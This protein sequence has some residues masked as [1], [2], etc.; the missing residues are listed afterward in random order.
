MRGD[1]LPRV[2]DRRAPRQPAR[3][4]RARRASSGC[5]RAGCRALRAVALRGAAAPGRGPVPS[6][7]TLRLVEVGRATLLRDAPFAPWIQP[8][9]TEQVARAVRYHAPQPS[10]V[11]LADGVDGLSRTTELATFFRSYAWFVPLQPGDVH[12]W[13][14]GAYASYDRTAARR[15]RR[16]LG[17]VPGDGADRRADG[18]VADVARRRAAAAAARRRDRS[19]A[20]RVHRARGGGAATRGRRGAPTPA[21][22]RCAA[23]A[24]G[25]A[26][27]RRDRERWRSWERSPA[28]ASAG[29]SPRSSP[30]TPGSPALAGR[31]ALAAPTG[32]GLAAALH[33][34]GRRGAPALP[35][36]PRD[37]ARRRPARAHAARRRRARCGRRRRGRLRA[38]IGRR[39]LARAAAAAERSCCSCR[40]SSRSPPRSVR[41]ACSLP[42]LRVL[43]RARPPRSAAR[44][45]ALSLARNPGQATVVATF[46][47]A[48]LG[49]A[50]F[51]VI[52]RATLLQGQH[53]QAYYAVPAPYVA[54]EDLSQL[55]PVLHG[56]HG[57]PRDSRPAA[58][59]QRPGDDRVHLPRRSRRR[60]SRLRPNAS[61]TVALPRGTRASRC[62]RRVQ[63]DDVAVR[64]WFRSPLGDFQA[65]DAS[66]RRTERQRVVLHGRIPFASAPARL[67]RARPDQLAAAS[68]RTPGPACSR[69]RRG[70]AAL[71]HARGRRNRIAAGVRGLGGQRRRS[72]RNGSRTALTAGPQTS[73]FRRRQPTDGRRCRCS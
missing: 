60:G 17:R 16:A 7:S 72:T 59:G 9:Q 56:W 48:S 12:P 58:L 22:G 25:A 39:R 61:R 66:A 73:S 55:V 62:R 23:L 52:Y 65:V 10:P 57:A 19:A 42:A 37:A 28:G 35:D 40:R 33:R 32:G 24:G 14:V 50:L 38:R 31:R 3:R 20:A 51:A 11:L 18:S 5:A 71:R 49:L 4:E 21:L 30:R 69:R 47:V 27:V 53:D 54:T 1:A 44:L 64:A 2:V 63:G 34:G 26:H 45:A 43:G 13:S 46:L 6:K 8:V 36:R 68:P 70:T 41:S 15:A 29:G 67:A